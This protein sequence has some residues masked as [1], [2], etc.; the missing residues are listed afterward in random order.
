M[1][2]ASNYITQPFCFFSSLFLYAVPCRNLSSSLLFIILTIRLLSPKVFAGDSWSGANICC[3][4][5]A[6]T[7]VRRAESGRV[8][9]HF[10][11]TLAL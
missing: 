3:Y 9:V 7:A 6:G 1:K 5:S 10:R 11:L 2:R 4:S 8:S